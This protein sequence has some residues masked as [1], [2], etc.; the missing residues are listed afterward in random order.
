M[1]KNKQ[2]TIYWYENNLN[3]S[4]EIKRMVDHLETKFSKIKLVI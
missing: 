4:D 3:V 2:M 1:I